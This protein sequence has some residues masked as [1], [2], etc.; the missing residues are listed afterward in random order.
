[1]SLYKAEHL[2]VNCHLVTQEKCE[3]HRLVQNCAMHT[4]SCTDFSDRTCL[5]HCRTVIW[6]L[7]SCG[8]WIEVL[9]FKNFGGSLS[10][11]AFFI[12]KSFGCQINFVPGTRFL[13]KKIKSFCAALQSDWHFASYWFD[14]SIS[15]KHY[16]GSAFYMEKESQLL[17]GVIRCSVKS[18]YLL[19]V[20]SAA[21]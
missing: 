3:V 4:L 15:S 5:T 18:E 2:T 9:L 17:L 20:C 12:I 21:F 19:V 13:E 14:L 6:R 11:L 8:F 16:S 7:F 10:E 1:M